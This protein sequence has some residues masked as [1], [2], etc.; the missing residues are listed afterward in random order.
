MVYAN[1]SSSHELI[2]KGSDKG[3]LFSKQFNTAN[4]TADL[5]KKHTDL[6]FGSTTR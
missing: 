4:A 3:G 5:E 2:R 1:N 6:T